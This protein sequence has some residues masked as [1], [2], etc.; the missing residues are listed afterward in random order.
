MIH[1]TRPRSFTVMVE[2]ASRSSAREIGA[3]LT[4]AFLVDLDAAVFVA[5]EAFLARAIAC[6]AKATGAANRAGNTRGLLGF[7][8]NRTILGLRGHEMYVWVRAA[9]RVMSSYARYCRE[10]AG[11]CARRARV[12]SSPQ[13]AANYRTLENRWLNLAKKAELAVVG[14][15]LSNTLSNGRI[16]E[17][18]GAGRPPKGHAQPG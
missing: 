18:R 4:L 8:P 12:A 9:E 10:H 16:S 2:M 17:P 11:D 1:D 13:V 3:Q 14:E 15:P 6:D 7:E 5:L